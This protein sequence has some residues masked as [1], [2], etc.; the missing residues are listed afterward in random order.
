[1]PPPP[2]LQ[3]NNKTS[4]TFGYAIRRQERH[5]E[6]PVG[7]DSQRTLC[8]PPSPSYF[9]FYPDGAPVI[10]PFQVWVAVMP[11]AGRPRGDG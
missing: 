6:C 7:F 11:S 5:W 3:S 1:M 4:V 2:Q 9:Q 8:E 10:T